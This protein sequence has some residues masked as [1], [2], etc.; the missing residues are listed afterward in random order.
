MNAIF[1]LIDPIVLLEMSVKFG[2]FVRSKPCVVP[3][4]KNL[5]DAAHNKNVGT[6]CDRK[7]L[8]YRHYSESLICRGHH[9]EQEKNTLEFE[10]KY[11]VNLGLYTLGLFIEFLTGIEQ[12][13]HN[14]K[15]VMR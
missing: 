3:G 10:T 6:G 8:S 5:P 2:A 7:K 4:C 15:G 13:F 1:K 12:P 14:D 11:R 9:Q